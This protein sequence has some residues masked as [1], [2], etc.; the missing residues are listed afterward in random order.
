ML[1]AAGPLTPE[2]EKPS[3]TVKEAALRDFICQKTPWKSG[4]KD[5]FWLH[6]FYSQE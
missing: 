1:Q 5:Y 2:E 4:G 3:M 6:F